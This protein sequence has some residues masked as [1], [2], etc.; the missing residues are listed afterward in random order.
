MYYEYF[1]RNRQL[2]KQLL[3]LE[4]PCHEEIF[5][6]CSLLSTE[7]DFRSILPWTVD[8]ECYDRTDRLFVHEDGMTEF[9]GV[10]SG[11]LA[12]SATYFTQST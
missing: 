12:L 8:R 10:G 7:L 11:A 1:T 6:G 3:K 2:H 4:P 5:Y 9:I